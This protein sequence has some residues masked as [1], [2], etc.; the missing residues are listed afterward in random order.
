[1]HGLS[2]ASVGCLLLRSYHALQA[3]TRHRYKSSKP[4]APSRSEST[5]PETLP[6]NDPNYETYKRGQQFMIVD[7]T[8]NQRNGSEISKI[9]QH[10]EE[11]R[12]VD[13]GTMD[14]YWRCGHVDTL[15][16]PAMSTGS[17]AVQRGSLSLREISWRRTL[18]RPANA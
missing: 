2:I 5:I 4:K 18:S 3:Q 12:R 1:L 7:N 13:D 9:W 17:S 16:C 15:S 10:G 8:G 11:R 6:F 14:R